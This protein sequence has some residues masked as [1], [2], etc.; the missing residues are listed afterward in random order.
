MEGIVQEIPGQLGSF[1]EVA[2][3]Y[4]F[5]GII[6]ITKI[7]VRHLFLLHSGAKQLDSSIKLVPSV[8]NSNIHCN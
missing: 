4:P 7:Y 3:Q 2:F 5:K 1:H 6:F 8:F